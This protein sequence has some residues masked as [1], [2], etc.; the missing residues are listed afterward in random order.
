MQ[1]GDINLFHVHGGN[2]TFMSLINDALMAIFFFSV[3]LEIK[4]EI[5]V[6]ELSSPA[7]LYFRLSQLAEEC[8]SPS[9]SFP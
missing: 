4:R 5:L 8:S 7:K 1:F 2:M 9:S 3:G 6:G